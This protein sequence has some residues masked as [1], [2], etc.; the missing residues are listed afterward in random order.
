MEPAC[1][2]DGL[3]QADNMEAD[4]TAGEDCDDE[5]E[6]MVGAALRCCLASLHTSSRAQL[7]VPRA[8]LIN[9]HALPCPGM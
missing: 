2:D 3:Y 4:I 1:D 8:P 9:M 7:V 6:R 5:A